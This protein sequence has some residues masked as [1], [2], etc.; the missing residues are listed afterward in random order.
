[1][2]IKNLITGV[3]NQNELLN[4]H[5][6]SLIF[7]KLPKVVK[8]FVYNYDSVYFVTINENLSCNKAKDTILHELAH[9][10]LNQLCQLRENLFAYCIEGYEDEAN[11]YIKKI[12]EEIENE[13]RF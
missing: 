9:I 2:N 11:K 6:A 7:K 10:E 1:M 4:Y 13:N 12:K 8:G 5:N 3:I